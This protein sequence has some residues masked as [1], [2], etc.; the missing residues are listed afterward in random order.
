MVKGPYEP[1]WVQAVRN[2]LPER[3]TRG[4]VEQQYGRNRYLF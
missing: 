2:S 4:S 1:G 3:R